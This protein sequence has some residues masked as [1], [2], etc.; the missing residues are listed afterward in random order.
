MLDDLPPFLTV[1][2]AGK[3]LQLGRSK[4]YELTVE[5]ERT[6]GRVRHPVRLVRQPE[7][8][9]ARRAD[10]LG[11]GA[12]RPAAGGVSPPRSPPGDRRV[13]GDC[14]R[15]PRPAGV[16]RARVPASSGPTTAGTVA[17]SVRVDRWR[18]LGVAKNTAHRGHRRA[19]RAPALAR[20]ESGPRRRRPLPARPLPA[21]RRRPPQPTDA[22]TPTTVV[23][24]RHRRTRD[25]PPPPTQLIAPHPGL[26]MRTHV[27]DPTEPISTTDKCPPAAGGSRAAGDDHPRQHRGSLG[28]LL[29][30]LPR[31]GRPARARASG[32]AAR[33]PGSASP[34]AVSTDDLE[35]LLS[36]HDP[37][38]GTRLGTR[39]R[40]PLRRQGQAD[41]G[42][43]RASTPRSR[44][45]SR[46]RC[47]GASPATRACSRPTTSRSEPCSTTSSGTAPPPGSGS[48]A[49]ASTPTPTGLTMA[50]FRQATS[51][52]DDPQLHTHVV[53]S[54]KVQ[55]ADGRW[56]A[57]DARYLKR[58]QRALGGL[59]QSVL[60]A[61]L[62]HRYGVAWGP[63]VNGQAEIAGMPAELLDVFS[64][65]TAQVD[66]ALAD[67]LAEFREREGRDPS[68]W[69]RAALTREAAA[70]T[71]AD[72]DRH[73][74]RRP[75]RQLA[76]RGGRAR[77]DARPPRRRHATPRARTAPGDRRRHRRRG[78]RAA[79]GQRLDLDRAPTCSK[80]SATSP[81]PCRSCRDATGPQR[82]EHAL[83][84]GRRRAAS[85][86][87][88]P[89]AADRCAPSD[90]RSIWLAPIEPHLTHERVLAQ[91]E[92]ILAL[93]HRRPRASQP[94]PSP[95]RR[96]S[97]ASTC[98]RPTP[99]RPSPATTGSCWSSA[100]PAPARPP[101]CAAPPTTSAARAAPC[102]AS[103]RR[104]RPP[105][106]CATRP[107]MPADTVAKLLY[108]WRT[109]HAAGDRT[110]SRP[111]PRSS[112]TRPGWSAPA[113]STSSSRLAVSQQ[114]RLVLVGDPRQLQAVGR[115]G[116]FDELCRT[117]RTHELAT[118][119]RFRH[120]WEQAASLQLRAGN[121]DALDA[122]L[123]HGR[124]TAGT[125]DDLA[126][127][128]ARQLD[129]PHR[130]WPHA[131]PS[132]PRPTSTSTPST[133]P[134]SRQ[135]RALGHLGRPGRP[136]RRRRDGGRRRHRR[137]PPQRPN[138]PH[139]PRRTGPQPRPL[140]RHRRRP[141]RQ[142]H[143]VPPPRTRHGDP[144]RRLRPS[145]RPARLRRHRPRPPRR[146]R[147]RRPRR[148]HR[149]HHP[150]QPLRRRHPRPPREPPPRRHR[151]ARPRGPRRPRTGPHQ[152]PRRHPRRHPAPPPRPPGSA[153]AGSRRRGRR[154]PP[155]T[156]RRQA[157]RRAIHPTA[158]RG[159]AGR[160]RCR[161]RPAVA[162]WRA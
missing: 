64:K 20:A 144:P 111:A 157:P 92:R 112:S 132:S 34:G 140:D 134:S 82:V 48:T 127:D 88:P 72:Q 133:P 11:R 24:R 1:E 94:Q 105:R 115:G 8:G 5:W 89:D 121:P 27:L 68:R 148:R 37:T 77:L 90:G 84:P 113:P 160:V 129:R 131:S 107:A 83:R 62:T 102:S 26:T 86:L 116:M 47:G 36:G 21:P 120:R 143:R 55:T 3:V 59:Y 49:P 162:A 142:P 58:K 23:A 78:P 40:R 103:L 135:R 97:T 10:P 156:R 51:R 117:G 85:T 74:R 35:A 65:R 141:G 130:R 118:I 138:P 29:H 41:P 79:L 61:E 161:G 93:R 136:R 145:P 152:R 45:R 98:S 101:R 137:H 91:E 125:F 7:A 95:T 42:G 16:V 151:R 128:G 159:R 70:D 9:P 106:S 66:A 80:P 96:P 60:R 154:S 99:P 53:I 43:G 33:P 46:C 39:A 15:E 30:P 67:K 139:R 110:G 57:L 44:R 17:A 52:E 71:R 22:T 126:A 124:V 73:A 150:P 31:R 75:R 19:G 153:L 81:R 119:H 38:T 56:L 147:R 54:T 28:A 50:A 123:D 155:R 149:R 122:Y 100:R 2:Q 18:D 146:H 12:A 158:R 32:S 109:G 25:Q 114:W 87:D 104:P 108:E 76:R 6:G 69:E 63:I 14:A 4:T 13:G